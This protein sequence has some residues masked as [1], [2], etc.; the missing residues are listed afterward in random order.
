MCIKYD[1][2]LVI[3]RTFPNFFL[4]TM[5]SSNLS[6]II[7]GLDGNISNLPIFPLVNFF[8]FMNVNEMHIKLI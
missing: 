5:D 8:M 4:T 3:I 2:D 1:Q 7:I 6:T